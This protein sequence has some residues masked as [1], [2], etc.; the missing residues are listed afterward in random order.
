MCSG[1]NDII[2]VDYPGHSG[3]SNMSSELSLDGS[4]FD[5]L[6]DASDTMSL[7]NL[8]LQSNHLSLD[9]THYNLHHNN[10]N[11]NNNLSCIDKLTALCQMQNQYFVGTP[12]EQW[13]Q[14]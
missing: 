7:Q 4:N 10:N 3:D 13:G 11:N 6:D 2:L 12:V 5:H 14:V 1:T 8:D 9:A